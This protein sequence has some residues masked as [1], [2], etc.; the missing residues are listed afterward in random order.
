MVVAAITA[1]LDP[2]VNLF[3]ARFESG[4]GDCVG[5][6]DFNE[7][8]VMAGPQLMLLDVMSGN[9][10]AVVRGPSRLTILGVDCDDV[11]ECLG[12]V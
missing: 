7:G 9:G 6:G 12:N 8:A 2:S 5:R 4:E 10:E 1:F 11:S 3:E